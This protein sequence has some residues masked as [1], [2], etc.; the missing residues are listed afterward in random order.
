MQFNYKP[1]ILH[2]KSLSPCPK[3][4]FQS[5]VCLYQNKS[6][7]HK[8]RKKERK[9]ESRLSSS[10]FQR[11]QVSNSSFPFPLFCLHSS[12]FRI[13]FQSSIKIKNSFLNQLN[14]ESQSIFKSIPLIFIITSINQ[15]NYLPF[16]PS[17][18]NQYLSSDKL[19]NVIKTK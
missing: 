1:S 4:R 10:V 6:R 15:I 12:S 18:I 13:E 2:N 9:K 3:E 16:Q 5:R 8:E 7:L 19:I 17:L 11:L 14:N